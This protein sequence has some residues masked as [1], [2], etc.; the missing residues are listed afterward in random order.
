MIKEKFVAF[1]NQKLKEEFEYLAKGKFEDKKLY[2]FINRAMDDMKRNPTCGTKIPR[3]LWPKDYVKKYEIN[4]LWKYDLP[5]AW[6]LIYT[7]DEDKVKILNI[8]L[9]WFDHKDYE[10]RFGY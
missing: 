10:R 6:R 7:I 5:N 1:V 3:K 9:E 8:I 4:N 2:E